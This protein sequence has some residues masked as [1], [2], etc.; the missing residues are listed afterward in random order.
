MA[1]AIERVN[2]YNPQVGK[3]AN[4]QNSAVLRMLEE[5][6]SRRSGYVGSGDNIPSSLRDVSWPPPDFEHKNQL[7]STFKDVVTPGV[8][9]VAWPPPQEGVLDP[10]EVVEQA[11]VQAQGGTQYTSPGLQQNN[12][13][14]QQSARSN[15]SQQPSYRPLKPLDVSSVGA[16]SP[17][18]SPSTNQTPQGFRTATPTRG[19]APV[20]SPVAAPTSQKYFGAP[21]QTQ[22]PYQPVQAPGQQYGGQYQPPQQQYQPPQQQYQ[23][24]QQQY[25]PPQQ[26][27]QPPQQQYQPPQQQYQPPQQQYQPPQ[28]QY[29]PPQQQ[30]QPPQQQY[31]P[32]QYQA[33]SFAQPPPQS[34]PVAAQNQVAAPRTQTKPV[35]PPPSTITLR[36]TAPVSQTPAP[37]YSAQ[38][39]TASL[40]VV[41]G[42]KHLRGDLKWPPENVRQQMAEEN[43]LRIELAKGPAVRPLRKDKDYTPFFEQHALNSSYP[44]YKIP[45]GTQFFRPE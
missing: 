33:Q 40:K 19:W 13:Q 6:E 30:Y 21:P 36:P 34:Q 26:Q 10:A 20:H 4:L 27:Y 12:Y 41:V 45:P 35:E 23:P 17:L 16:G 39:A 11:P 18:A 24:P 44:G 25:Q 32:P 31:Q 29:Q 8:K 5:E 22:P 2:F 43:R 1:P 28:Q 14:P 38:P 37:V 42:G 7:R 3:P 9:R 15:Q